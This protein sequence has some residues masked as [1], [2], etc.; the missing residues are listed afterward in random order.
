M[1]AY[2]HGDLRRGLVEAAC[3]LL[4]T[5]SADGLSLRQVARAAGVSHNAPY[6]HFE[7]KAALLRAIADHGFTVMDAALVNAAREPAPP[8]AQLLAYAEGYLAF[9]AAQ[10]ELYRVMFDGVDVASP[11]AGTPGAIV[12]GRLRAVVDAGVASGTFAPDS[13]PYAAWALMHGAASLTRTRR[14]PPHAALTA[15]H[16]LIRGMRA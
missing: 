9:A 7:D 1:S 3:D 5:T 13:T 12:F 10:P 8:D 14:L 2:H 4:K 15:A 11:G 6:R 16:T